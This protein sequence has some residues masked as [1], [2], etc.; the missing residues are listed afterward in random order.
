[1]SCRFAPS[2]LA[3]LI[4]GCGDDRAALPVLADWLDERLG[5]TATAALLRQPARPTPPEEACYSDLETFALAEDVSTWL[6]RVCA[7]PVLAGGTTRPGT[8]LGLYVH[9]AGWP[10]GWARLSRFVPRTRCGVVAARKELRAFT[11]SQ[12]VGP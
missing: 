6:V 9:P 7:D 11:H 10:E 1:M 2:E 12:G 3:A 5:L 4:P 8:L